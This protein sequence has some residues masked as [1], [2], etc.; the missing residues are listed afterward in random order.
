MALCTDAA[1]V[2]YYD[3]AGDNGDHD[4]WHT[5]EHLHER[6]S[7]PGF[8][9]GTRWIAK[10]G[11]PRYM[12]I[13]EVADIDVA[14]SPA[15]LA[16]L[17]DPTPW[18]Q[19]MMPRFRG[20]TRGFCTV[21]ASAGCGLGNAAVSIRFAIADEKAVAFT[22]R[23]A[24]DVLSAIS[25]ER[26]IAAAHLLRPAAPPPMTKEQSLRGADR[27]MSWLLLATGY[28]A[29]ALTETVARHA[30]AGEL[31]RLGAS[32]VADAVSYVLDY[33]V[34]A[35]EVARTAPKP[36]VD[37]RTRMSHGSRS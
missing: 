3:I 4:D 20:M 32:S 7:I 24:R 35:R 6:L 26:G 25:L 34:T 33:S 14:T 18:T 1:M 16:R 28:D 23:L 36:A 10:S 12:V 21:A 17:D 11:S 8:E 27:P 30:G 5:Y 9:R 19:S 15:Y 2:L 37:A 31:E 13:Y 22:E 29:D